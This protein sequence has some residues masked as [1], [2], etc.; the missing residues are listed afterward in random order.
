MSKQKLTSVKGISLAH[1][2]RALRVLKML[3][4]IHPEC[5]F[6]LRREWWKACEEA[7]H[8]PYVTRQEVEVKVP[9]Y[10]EDEDGDL[11]LIE[12]KVKKKVVTHPNITQVA[13]TRSINDGRGP[14]RFAKEKGFRQLEEMGFAPLCQML[15]C[16]LEATI[17]TPWGE[18]CGRNHA[19][20]VAAAED[21]VA[22]E[23]L[24]RRKRDRQLRAIDISA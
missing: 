4:P 6:P 9:V 15:N 7:G 19:R 16:W 21:G 10:G 20:L 5:Q 14:E 18:F 3:Q 13:L 12:E 2:N 1:S 22:L 24:D 17:T 11:V 23:V 8:E